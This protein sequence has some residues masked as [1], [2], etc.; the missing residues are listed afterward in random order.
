MKEIS[1]LEAYQRMALA[2]IEYYEKECVKAEAE[3]DQLET[4]LDKLDKEL[5][6]VRFAATGDR[7]GSDKIL[8]E[9][10]QLHV[11]LHENISTLRFT[12]FL[13]LVFLT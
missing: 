8:R 6:L 13:C 1:S 4:Q 7:Q 3:R 2:R 5:E 10:R 9:N 12:V 11:Q